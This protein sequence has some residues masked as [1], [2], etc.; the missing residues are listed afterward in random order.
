MLQAAQGPESSL[1][2]LNNV[3]VLQVKVGEVGSEEEGTPGQ[4][5][6]VVVPQVKFHCNLIQKKK[7]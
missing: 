7:T 3:A 5:P 2:H 1:L 6:Q 4:I